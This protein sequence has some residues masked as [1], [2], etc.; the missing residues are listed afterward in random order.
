MQGGAL[1]CM[2][3]YHTYICIGYRAHTTCLHALET[4]DSFDVL[5]STCHYYI[6]QPTMVRIV[7]AMI[8]SH[9]HIYRQKKKKRRK[10]HQYIERRPLAH[11]SRKRAVLG[12]IRRARARAKPKQGEKKKHVWQQ[13]AAGTKCFVRSNGVFE[14]Q[15]SS[16]WFRHRF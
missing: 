5:A 7:H 11:M 9:N 4:K 8:T 6:Y 12:N 3:R 14:I 10:T 2:I 15:R 1:L 13:A 16:G